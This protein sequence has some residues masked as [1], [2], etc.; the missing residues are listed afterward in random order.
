MQEVKKITILGSTGSI[1]TQALEVLERLEGSLEFKFEISALAA[2]ANIELLSEQI[3]K[4]HPKKVC[5]QN[6]AD[7]K[8]IKSEYPFLEVFSGDDGLVEL[9]ANTKHDTVLAATSGSRGLKPVLAAIES[10]ANIALANKEALVMGGETV[11]KLASAK[12]VRIIPVDSEHSAIFQCTE[13]FKDV[14]KLI[15]TASGGPFLRVGIEE[16]SKATA[17]D[18]LK[19]PK[20]NMGKK[21]TI[22][23]STLMNKGLEVIEA[24]YLFSMPPDKIEVV[25]HPQSIVHS[26]VEFI[27]GSTIAQLGVASMHIPIQ[28]ALTYPKRTKGLKSGSFSF[29]GQNLTFEKPDLNKFPCLSLAYE[30]LK[31]GGTMPTVLNAA[32]DC[33]VEKFLTGKTGI[34]AIAETIEKMMSEH[35]LIKDPSLEDIFATDE[36]VREKLK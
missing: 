23:S 15:I 18:A 35:K 36:H 26:A 17:E 30:A 8:V 20:W 29:L 24:H 31:T 27:D 33:A 19:H 9:C 14:S 25:I 32:N 22:D 10:G 2:G 5:V 34:S 7:A 28:Y 11:M 6:G 3:K 21:I 16:M 13:D 1:G 4:F 12:G